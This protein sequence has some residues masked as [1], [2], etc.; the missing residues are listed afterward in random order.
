[1]N[2][3]SAAR[4]FQWRPP[5]TPNRLSQ[6]SLKA[7]SMKKTTF[8]VSLSFTPLHLR[9]CSHGCSWSRGACV[10]YRI[11]SIPFQGLLSLSVCV[12]A[13]RCYVL[14]ARRHLGPRTPMKLFLRLPSIS[15]WERNVRGP[16]VRECRLRLIYFCAQIFGMSKLSTRF[17]K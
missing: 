6:N 2:G 1:M 13:R 11:R 4:S 14:A 5:W 12:R 3:C 9:L 15:A 8:V 10:H 16:L 7:D 17:R